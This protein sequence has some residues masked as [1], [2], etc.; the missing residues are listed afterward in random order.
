[1]SSPLRLSFV[2][3]VFNFNDSHNDVTPVP[4]VLFPVYEKRKEKSELLMDA[5]CVFFRFHHS[6]QVERLSCLI[7]ALYSMTL[8]LFLQFRCLFA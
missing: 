3:V 5:F 2:S 8:L 1:M 6:N 4:P 7:S